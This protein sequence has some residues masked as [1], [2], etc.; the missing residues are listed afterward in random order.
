VLELP[1]TKIATAADTP[2]RERTSPKVITTIFAAS[3]FSLPFFLYRAGVGLA[4]TR[5]IKEE[6]GRSPFLP[7][8]ERKLMGLA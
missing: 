3:D 4:L 5:Y 2:P 7:I 8:R 1:L 6:F